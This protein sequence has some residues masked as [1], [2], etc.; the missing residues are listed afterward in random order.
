MYTVYAHI[1]KVNGKIYIG[2][3]SQQAE[4]RWGSN[5][6]GYCNNK[7]FWRAIQKYGWDNFEHRILFENLSK[8]QACEIECCLIQQLKTTDKTY[9]YNK[10]S[11][12]EAPASG[13]TL[14]EESRK[15]ISDK[16]KGRTFSDEHRERLSNSERGIKKPKLSEER[17]KQI[18]NFMN[19]AGNPRA[20]KVICIETGEIFGCIKEAAD[21]IGVSRKVL[22]IA[23][24]NNVIVKNLHWTYVL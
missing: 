13:I 11:G 6:S 2:L 16:L 20:K 14:S 19:G 17:K 7:H 15:K 22:S 24:K 5:G 23:L 4:R 12:G 1:N 3:T 8:E 18:S 21:S 9:G 10:S